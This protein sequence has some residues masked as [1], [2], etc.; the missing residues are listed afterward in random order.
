MIVIPFV[1]NDGNC[2]CLNFA[3]R[4]IRTIALS[5][6]RLIQTQRHHS[7][8]SIE[9]MVDQL[10]E[11]Q[12]AEFKEATRPRPSFSTCV[13]Q[14]SCAAPVAVAASLRDAPAIA[15]NNVFTADD[16]LM[17]ELGVYADHHD[18]PE[19]DLSLYGTE[20][21]WPPR[22]FGQKKSS[23]LIAAG[24]RTFTQLLMV[25]QS[26]TIKE[27]CETY[28]VFLHDPI[29]IPKYRTPPAYARAMYLLVTRWALSKQRE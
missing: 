23:A 7:D 8:T 17:R 15:P 29:D 1:V 28:G 24:I 12:I 16:H 26:M 6:G 3:I 9:D 13:V 11:E 22:F 2:P 27:F 21:G 19:D 10:T 14:A 20:N 18:Y 4:S 25:V 5:S